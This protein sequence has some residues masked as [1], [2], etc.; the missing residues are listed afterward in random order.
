MTSL[1]STK[2]EPSYWGARGLVTKREGN[3]PL[4]RAWTDLILLRI[5]TSGGLLLTR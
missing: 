2:I 4:G 5:G 1:R 3:G